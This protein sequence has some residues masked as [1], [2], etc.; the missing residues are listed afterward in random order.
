M[1]ALTSGG[2]ARW[3]GSP[4]EP[5]LIRP[6]T[7]GADCQSA[8]LWLIQPDDL[9]NIARHFPDPKCIFVSEPWKTGETY[10]W[11]SGPDGCLSMAFLRVTSAITMCIQPWSRS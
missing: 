8:L 2:P 11:L 5:R 1:R 9:R 7:A 3:G 4:D 6:A 10:G